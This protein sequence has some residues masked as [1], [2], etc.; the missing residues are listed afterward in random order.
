MPDKKL[1]L[2]RLA[3]EFFC[4]SPDI[5]NQ[6][7]VDY[8]ASE[9]REI[10]SKRTVIRWR[11]AQGWDDYRDGTASNKDRVVEAA[12]AMAEGKPDPQRLFAVNRL[13]ELLQTDEEK[14]AFESQIKTLD[15]RNSID[16]MN[17]LEKVLLAQ[18][19][20]Q[21]TSGNPGTTHLDALNKL[22]SAREDLLKQ[23]RAGEERNQVIIFDF[24]GR[25]NC[26]DTDESAD[27]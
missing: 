11:R 21:I 14:K 18:I 23:Q 4:S 16:I 24:T 5:S 13:I 6:M 10:I 17:D 8:L 22:L 9:H 2:S 27:V 1:K 25:A 7:V 12:T 26:G 20:A 19:N 15:G 3:K